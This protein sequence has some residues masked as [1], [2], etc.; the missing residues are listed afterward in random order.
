MQKKGQMRGATFLLQ[1]CAKEYYCVP[2]RGLPAWLKILLSKLMGLT[3][4]ICCNFSIIVVQRE[5]VTL[6]CQV[7]IRSLSVTM[8]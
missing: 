8:T 6:H 3:I 5:L 1:L 4:L 2:A 7:S